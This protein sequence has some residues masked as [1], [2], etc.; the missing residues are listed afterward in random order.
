MSNATYQTLAPSSLTN[1]CEAMGLL[2]GQVERHLYR[3]LQRGEKINTLKKDYQVRFGINARQ[4]NSVHSSIKGKID[5]RQ[6]CHKRQVAEVTNRIKG[7]EK[8]LKKLF[9]QLKS[10][11]NSC[12]IKGKSPR[13]ILRWK[14]HQKQR[15][16]TALR[17]KLTALKSEKPSL[18]FGGKKLWKAQFNL[19]ANGYS[20]HEEWSYDWQSARSSQFMLVGSKDETAGC[21]NCQ[22][23]ADGAIKI[24]VPPALEHLF[25]KH[26]TATGIQFAYGQQDIDYALENGQ[27]L[28]YRFVRKS[29][30]WYIFCTTKRKEVPLQSRYANGVMGVDLNPGVIGWAITDAQGNLN[31][32]GQIRL[33]LNDRSSNQIEA[34]LGDAVKQLVDIASRHLCPIAV[35]HLDFSKKKASMKQQG[36]KYSRMLSNFSYSKSGEMLNSRASREGIEVIHLNP[37]YSSLIGLAKFMSLYGLGSDTAAAMVLARRALR[38]SERVPANLARFLPED[39]SRHSW[40]YWNWLKKKL[41]G[42]RRHDFFDRERRQQRDGGHASR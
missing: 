27:A 23:R 6:E 5:S 26:V 31:D 38:K 25:G 4:F 7:L 8:S 12:G 21:Q 14:L 40:S 15:L 9:K 19:E 1:F 3:V 42:L 2:F 18:I 37:A 39:R 20:S 28:T 13:G 24:R 32:K 36:V 17:D 29:G 41:C 10:S 16:L 30:K 33:N 22:I 34:T 11:H 35:E